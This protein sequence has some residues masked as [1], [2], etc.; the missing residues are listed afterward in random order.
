L[1]AALSYCA[2]PKSEDGYR[3]WVSKAG[4]SLRHRLTGRSCNRALGLELVDGTVAL[5]DREVAAHRKMPPG[6]AAAAPI[7]RRTCPPHS[8]RPPSSPSSSPPRLPTPR[9]TFLRPPPRA[10][11]RLP[12]AP[13]RAP[14]VRALLRVRPNPPPRPHRRA[15]TGL[16][17][18]RT[19]HRVASRIRNCVPLLDC[20]TPRHPLSLRP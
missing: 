8:R 15:A 12:T 10:R 16:M 19:S 4:D 5:G 2:S 14:P 13:Q 17:P 18:P 3:V 7:G 11:R 6:L 1:G 9:S 20:W